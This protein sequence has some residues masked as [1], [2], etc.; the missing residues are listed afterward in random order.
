M[1]TVVSSPSVATGFLI[2]PLSFSILW[3]EDLSLRVFRIDS[4]QKRNSWRVFFG[5]RKKLIEISHSI[6]TVIVL[7]ACVLSPTNS[8]Q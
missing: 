3:V 5:G 4:T 6:G 1:T 8:P 2:S 7:P